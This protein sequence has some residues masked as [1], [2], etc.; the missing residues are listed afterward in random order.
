VTRAP[1]PRLRRGRLP[2]DDSG[3]GT[4][5]VLALTAVV[6]CVAAA[7]VLMVEV[8]VA[9]AEAATA[10]DLAALA[11]A[12]RLP[13]PQRACASAEEVALAQAARLVSC[14]TDGLTVEVVVSV[15]LVGPLAGLPDLRMRSRAGPP[16]S[17]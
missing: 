16:G 12:G 2:G 5:W 6:A 11:A 17:R 8:R 14:T 4:V 13:D 15:P 10:A 7:L 1:R 3:S 9:R